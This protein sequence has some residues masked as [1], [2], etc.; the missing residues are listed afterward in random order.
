MLLSLLLSANTVYEHG[1]LQH[2][3]T[4]YSNMSN[5]AGEPRYI[6]INFTEGVNSLIYAVTYAGIK[7]TRRDQK[8]SRI[9]VIHF[10]FYTQFP[11]PRVPPCPNHKQ[12]DIQRP[13]RRDTSGV[14]VN[15]QS[16]RRKGP[17]SSEN[18]SGSFCFYKQFPPS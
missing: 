15:I 9:K 6:L 16:T 3:S 12:T 10:C 18:R 11:P 4:W 17:E 7:V 1:L 2:C 13:M 5:Q 8:A 14:Q